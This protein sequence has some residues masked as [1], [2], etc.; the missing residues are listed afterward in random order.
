MANL[1]SE[2]SSSQNL[3]DILS[4][5]DGSDPV[6]S[7]NCSV[8]TEEFLETDLYR[9]LSCTQKT[10]DSVKAADPND[11]LNSNVFCEICILDCI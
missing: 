4:P 3:N 11:N 2:S 10:D 9:C 7:P 1:V 6:S 8:C 5:D